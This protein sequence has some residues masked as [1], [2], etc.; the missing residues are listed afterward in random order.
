[1]LGDL[2]ML[3]HFKTVELKIE[4]MLL[5]YNINIQKITCQFLMPGGSIGLKYV[6]QLLFSEKITKLP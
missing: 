5:K 4:K 1:M 6:L 3:A 2:E